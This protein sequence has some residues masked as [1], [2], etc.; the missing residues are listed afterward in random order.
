MGRA[1]LVAALGAPLLAWSWMRLESGHDAGQATLVVLLAI[2]AALVRPR[3]AR[4]AACC[5]SRCSLTGAIAFGVGHVWA[6]PGRM[7]SRFGSGFL[8][9]Y[10]YQVP[11]DPA[12]HPRM[13]GVLLV[14]LFAFTLAFALAVAARRP[15]L[16]AIALVVGVG[17]PG[18]LL[19]GHD[20]LRG[21]LLLVAVLAHRGRA[22]ARPGAR[23]RRRAGR[24]HARP[25]RRARRHELARLRQARL[26]RLAALGPVHE[27]REAGRRLLRLELELQRAHLPRQA[28]DRHAREGRAGDAL[29]ARLGAEH[30][31]ARDVVRGDLARVRRPAGA[32][33]PRTGWSRRAS[34]GR[35]T[36]RSST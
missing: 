3:S 8:E 16:A 2:A 7:L 24:W 31:R 20:L 23:R 27:A 36:G 26:P 22:Q 32:A 35:T 10:D 1:L 13:H 25:A 9:F 4:I 18:T 19:P 12:V 30:R 33:R 6:L 11:F 17:W 5:R 28:D 14:A 34:C 29:L 15:G 21:C